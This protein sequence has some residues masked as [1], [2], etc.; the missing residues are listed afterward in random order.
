MVF[1]LD[2]KV[3]EGQTIGILEAMKVFSH[4]PADRAG[5]VVD[6]RARNGQLVQQGEALIAI[7]P[8]E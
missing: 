5:T 8:E 7:E 3:D 2:L 6:V 4:I 1:D